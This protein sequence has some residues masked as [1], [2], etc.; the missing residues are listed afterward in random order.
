[1][2]SISAQYGFAQWETIW[3]H[4]KNAA[5]KEKRKNPNVLAPGDQIFV[6]DPT[7]GSFACA[8][9]RRHTFQVKRAKTRL[10][11]QLVDGSGQPYANAAY[12]IEVGKGGKPSIKRQGTTPGNGVVDVLVPPDTTSGKVTLVPEGSPP[13]EAIE[14][15]LNLGH[16]DPVQEQSGARARLDNLFPRVPGLNVAEDARRKALLLAFQE[17]HGLPETGELDDATSQKLEQL[18]DTVT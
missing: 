8:T 5:I 10:R 1:M 11:L 15:Q 12:T 4:P 14:W 16:L 17:L 3:N 2:A 7:P 9:G 18:H 6:P 13:E